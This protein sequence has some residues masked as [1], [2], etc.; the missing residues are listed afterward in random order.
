LAD[1]TGFAYNNLGLPTSSMGMDSAWLGPDL[2][3]HVA[4]GNFS[5]EMT[6]LYRFDL[7]GVFTDIAPLSGIGADSRRA[8]T[9]GLVFADLDLDGRPELVQV[10][11]H[12]QPEIAETSNSETYRQPP[13]IFWNCG[14][15]CPRQFVLIDSAKTGDFAM[16]MPA[17]GLAAADYDGDGDLD[18]LVSSVNEPLR[19]FRNDQQSGNNWLRVSLAN[20]ESNT[21]GIGST[22]EI[23]A[24]NSRQRQLVKVT[25]SYLSQSETTL[26][27]GLGKA[28]VVDEITVR[29]PDGQLQQLS[30]IAA[31]QEL[32]I[33]RVRNGQ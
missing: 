11:G 30:G 32:R 23:V 6:S 19:L 29:W 1:A 17:R 7:P 26:T 12:V 8:L 13:Q 3:L 2:D 5:G 14:S 18:L 28:A 16:P 4:I 24:N 25:N 21:A 22:V 9:F 10:N 15:D 33:E 20:D 31:N 27:F